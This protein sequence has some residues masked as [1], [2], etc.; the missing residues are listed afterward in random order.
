MEQM[1]RLKSWYLT[2][3]D[4]KRLALLG[5]NPTLVT[6][7]GFVISYPLSKPKSIHRPSHISFGGDSVTVGKGPE[8]WPK[9]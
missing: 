9:I 8:T 7:V 4:R 6:M 1:V 5:K 3:R 2:Y